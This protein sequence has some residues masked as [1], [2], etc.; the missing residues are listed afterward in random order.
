M[1]AESLMREDGWVAVPTSLY[2][3]KANRLKP[4]VVQ[5]GVELY[6]VPSQHTYVLRESPPL[7][8]PVSYEQGAATD[9][10][11]SI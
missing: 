10:V 5:A 7:G 4:P 8:P 3:L 9:V 11:P 2:F 6:G 1:R